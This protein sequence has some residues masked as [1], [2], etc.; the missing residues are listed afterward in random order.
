MDDIKNKTG[1]PQDIVDHIAAFISVDTESKNFIRE[2]NDNQQVHL[3]NCNVQTI[4]NWDFTEDTITLLDLSYNSLKIVSD[5]QTKFGKKLRTLYLKDNK[6][7]T[8]DLRDTTIN[9]LTLMDNNLTN[10]KENLLLPQGLR[11]LYFGG[12]Q[13]GRL[14]DYKFLFSPNEFG[15]FVN[16]M[17]CGIFEL[18]DVEFSDLH[19]VHLSDNPI[20]KMQNV[21]F[22]NVCRVDMKRCGMT[23]KMLKTFS[24]NFTSDGYAHYGYLD[25]SENNITIQ[26]LDDAKYDFPYE[27]VQIVIDGQYY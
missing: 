27:D 5:K 14:F 9:V 16:L 12:N 17:E 7:K 6:I 13:I 4:E 11:Y 21:T 3:R 15:S 23:L 22:K 25:L 20:R 1:T 10:F 2:Y 24:L 26:Q 18:A 8:I 19:T